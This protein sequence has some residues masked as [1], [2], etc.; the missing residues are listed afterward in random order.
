MRR[1]TIKKKLC[2]KTKNLVQ[3]WLKMT[4]IFFVFFFKFRSCI[5]KCKKCI[6]L[7]VQQDEILQS[8]HTRVTSTQIKNKTWPTNTQ[9]PLGFPSSSHL[10]VPI[11][12][13]S[14]ILLLCYISVEA[15]LSWL[16]TVFMK[17]IY[18]VRCNCSFSFCVIC[19]CVNVPQFMNSLYYG[20]ALGYFHVGTITNSGAMDDHNVLKLNFISWHPFFWKMASLKMGYIK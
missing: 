1:T 3:K 19:H 14:N 4:I 12:L 2:E 7:S 15:F 9:R 11:M 17:F 5:H 20:G 13:T 6:I 8:D 16:Y 10:V 18:D